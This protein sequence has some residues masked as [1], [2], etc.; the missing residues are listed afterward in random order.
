[1]DTPTTN[2]QKHRQL[3]EHWYAKYRDR[4]VDTCEFTWDGPCDWE[5]WDRQVPKIVFLVKEAREG[6]HPE[7]KGQ[8]ITNKFGRNLLRWKNALTQLFHEPSLRISFPAQEQISGK[9]DDLVL[10]EV[11][12]LDEGNARSST[13]IINQY[14]AQ[15]GPLLRQQFALIGPQVVV[16]CSTFEAYEIIHD[17]TYT[18]EEQLC[19]V[20][21]RSSWN[22]DNRL[23]I[24]FC[25]PSIWPSHKP[26]GQNDEDAFQALQELVKYGAVFSHFK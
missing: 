26:D 5:L 16:Y 17:Y 20:E 7:L 6:F 2:E 18:K 15:D 13:P 19:T 14:A 10:I 1:M 4:E 9:L 8:E 22:L 11:K 23:V 21:K 3:L 25:H 12:K 24:D